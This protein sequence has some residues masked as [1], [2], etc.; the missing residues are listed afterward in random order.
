MNEHPTVE[1]LLVR[2]ALDHLTP[3]QRE[4][5]DY[6]SLDRLTQDE[7]ATKLNMKRQAVQ[8]H[9][10]AAARNVSKF[11]KQNRA[12][13]MLLKLEHKIMNEGTDNE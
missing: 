10:T 3:R 8:Q 12:A 13:Y 1:Q 4:I 11:V 2:M 5:W 9:L 6:Y 7:I